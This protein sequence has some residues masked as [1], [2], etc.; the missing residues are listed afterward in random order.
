MTIAEQRATPT[1]RPSMLTGRRWRHL[2]EALT[3][4]IFLL[5][6]FLIIGTFGLFPIGFAAYVS[7][8]RWRI[9]PGKYRGLANYVKALDNLAYVA[10]FWLVVIFLVLAI[11]ALLQTRRTA[12][13]HG[14]RPWLWLVPAAVTAGGLILFVRFCV[15]LL[16]EVLAIGEKVK[17]LERTRE[18]FL[19]LLGEAWR[20][21]TVQ[22]ALRLSLLI[23]ALGLG[24]AENVPGR[25]VLIDGFG[26]IAFASLFPIMSVMAYALLSNVW[27]HHANKSHSK[28]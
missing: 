19:R 16:P 26:L 10:A 9:V 24:L 8:H 12:R 25:S 18:L 20:A 22:S 23:L 3:A 13:E 1:P 21:P 28:N 11:R 27:A 2:K 6:A 15:C 14:D 17:G 4:Y 7:L 5:P